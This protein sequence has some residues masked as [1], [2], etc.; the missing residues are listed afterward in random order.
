MGGRGRV[1]RNVRL[2]IITNVQL[3]VLHNSVHDHLLCTRFLFPQV[4]VLASFSMLRH[5]LSATP[6]SLSRPEPLQGCEEEAMIAMK[7]NDRY[8]VGMLLSGIDIDSGMTADSTATHTLRHP[9]HISGAQD[10][11]IP[12]VFDLL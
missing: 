9:A 7:C 5:R 10:V 6:E 4:P 8:I 1:F 3:G 11:I 12:A 2:V